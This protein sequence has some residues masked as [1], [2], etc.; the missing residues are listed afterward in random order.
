MYLCIAPRENNVPISLLFDEHAEELSF[1]S[2]YLGQFRK[3]KEGIYCIGIY[4]IYDGN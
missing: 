2:I 3:F 4:G 1:P